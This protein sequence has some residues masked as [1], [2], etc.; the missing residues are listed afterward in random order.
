MNESHGIASNDEGDMFVRKICS[1]SPVA[2]SN[3]S[4]F[5]NIGDHSSDPSFRSGS[6][7][8]ARLDSGSSFSTANDIKEG[9]NICKNYLHDAEVTDIQ[10]EQGLYPVNQHSP[11]NQSNSIETTRP[12]SEDL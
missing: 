8:E 10:G 4:S 3:G 2:S 7:Q 6:A 1:D 9:Q 12:F 11:S 5:S